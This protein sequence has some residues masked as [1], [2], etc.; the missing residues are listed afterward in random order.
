[1]KKVTYAPIVYCFLLVVCANAGATL[2]EYTVVDFGGNQFEYKYS[3]TND[4]LGVA[5]E[6][7]TIWFD[8]DLYDNLTITTQQ[9]LAG[10]WNEIILEPTGFGVPIGYDALSE[11]GGIQL[12]KSVSGF[13][14]A[15]DWIGTGTPGSQSFEIIDPITFETIDSGYTVPEPATLFLLVSACLLFRRSRS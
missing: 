12:S 15:F 8:V 13:S 2:I 6:E 11:T 14:L 1:V 4:S 7:F 10:Q 9:P 3:I 5:I